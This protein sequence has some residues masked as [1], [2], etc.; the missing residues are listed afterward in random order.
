MGSLYS[1]NMENFAAFYK[2]ISSRKNPLI[3]E[4][5]YIQLILEGDWKS[6]R[7]GRLEPEEYYSRSFFKKDVNIFFF[8]AD[9]CCSSPSKLKVENWILLRRVIYFCYRLTYLDIWKKIVKNWKLF[10]MSRCNLTCLWI[11]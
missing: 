6:W 11:F 8:R 1:K 3:S 4:E 10:Q 2:T 5:W 7:R 9:C